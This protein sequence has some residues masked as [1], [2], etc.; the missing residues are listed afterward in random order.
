MHVYMYLL[1]LLVCPENTTECQYG[2]VDGQNPP[3]VSFDQRCDG[4][5]DCIGGDD[6]LDYNCPCEPEGAVRLVN[7]TFPYQG[8]V[9]FCTNGG[10]HT[11]CSNR[12]D[13]Y[14]ASVV[15]RQLGYPS[16]GKKTFM[17][18]FRYFVSLQCCRRSE[19]KGQFWV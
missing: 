4:T 2:R 3:C 11:L 16:G 13:Y 17:Y 6:E 9:E 19:D 12:W 10:W 1:I 15:C 5:D 14:A 7:G 8:R 18:V